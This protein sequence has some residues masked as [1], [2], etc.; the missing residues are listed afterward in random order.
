MERG[1][2]LAIDESARVAE[3]FADLRLWQ[4]RHDLIE[5]ADKF[6][7]R[8]LPFWHWPG[9]LGGGHADL[10]SRLALWRCCWSS[11]HA[12]GSL[13]DMDLTL[14]LE[15]LRATATGDFTGAELY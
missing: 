7:G 1:K 12:A 10:H 14:S 3:R 13:V 15:K 9:L 11:A 8:R 4:G 5:Y 6:I 2:H